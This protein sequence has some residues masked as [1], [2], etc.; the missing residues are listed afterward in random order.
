MIEVKIHFE[1]ED[2][3]DQIIQ[4]KFESLDEVPA[5]IE[6]IKCLGENCKIRRSVGFIGKRKE[7]EDVNSG[8]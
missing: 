4:A 8:S 1:N 7:T 2:D 3:K 5:W 6:K